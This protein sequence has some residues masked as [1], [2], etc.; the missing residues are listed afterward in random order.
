MAR[1]VDAAR[2]GWFDHVAA[3]LTIAAKENAAVAKRATSARP[4]PNSGSRSPPS[5]LDTDYDP[6][7]E[8]PDDIGVSELY[9][10]TDL[11][12]HGHTSHHYSDRDRAAAEPADDH[13]DDDDEDGEGVRERREQEAADA[14]R[15][16]R[17]ELIARSKQ[18]DAAGQVRRE[19]LRRCVTVKSRA[20]DGAA[21]RWRG[22]STGAAPTPYAARGCIRC[23]WPSC[24]AAPG[25]VTAAAPPARHPVLLWCHAVAAQGADFPGDSHRHVHTGRADYLRHLHAMGYPLADVDQILIDR[26]YPPT[27]TDDIAEPEVN[28]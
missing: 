16:E 26:A 18:G 15:A 8:P 21:G 19:Y 2:Y 7:D 13:D 6:D 9:I 24:W 27:P 4:T 1:L 10:C 3:V 5:W 20:S 17:R 22:W 12:A 11:A 14:R 25:Q 28:I 23:C